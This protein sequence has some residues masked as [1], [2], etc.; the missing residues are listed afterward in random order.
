MNECAYSFLFFCFTEPW[1]FYVW[2]VS[3]ILIWGFVAL[4]WKRK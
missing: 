3:M 1:K 4:T 2:L